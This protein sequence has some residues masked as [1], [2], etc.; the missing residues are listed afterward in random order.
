MVC[1]GS[2]YRPSKD[3]HKPGPLIG[4]RLETRPRGRARDQRRRRRRSHWAAR[5]RSVDGRPADKPAASVR[6]TGEHPR[7]RRRSA[8]RRG[9]AF[10]SKPR[11]RAASRSGRDRAP[12]SL[13]QAQAASNA[14]LVWRSRRGAAGHGCI[15]RIRERR[16]ENQP[17]REHARPIDA[18]FRGQNRES[19]RHSHEQTRHDWNE[20]SA[21]FCEGPDQ[22]QGERRQRRE[23]SEPAARAC[24]GFVSNRARSRRS[25]VRRIGS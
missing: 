9:V 18:A 4:R 7:H 19:F 21:R 24:V 11:P 10:A 25:S 17:R 1:F 3:I 20:E 14:S 8:R 2:R 13:I 5:E 22:E 23:A 16:R 15:D 6:L 12:C